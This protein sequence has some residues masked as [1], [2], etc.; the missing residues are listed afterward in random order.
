MAAPAWT[1]FSILAVG[2]AILV[3]LLARQTAALLEDPEG[4]VADLPRRGLY[5]NVVLSHGLVLL[6]VGGAVLVTGVPIGPF[7]LDVAPTPVAAAA[8]GVSVIAV[9]EI[10]DRIA[11]AL[12]RGDNPLRDRLTP[13][14]PGQWIL[15]AGVILPL[16]AA[17]EELLFRGALIGVLDA[18]TGLHPALLIA[19]SAIAFGGAHSAQGSLGVAMA[20]GI[21]LV[22]GIAYALTGSLWL[23]IVVHY[24]VD[25]IEFARHAD[26]APVRI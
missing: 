3:V 1:V 4:P 23:V 25:L 14:T 2:L 17:T 10:A 22:F 13:D 16:V 12:D 26:V 8:L 11:S 21:G 24:V 6:A 5:L 15:L 18:G 19:A 7:G 20:T 9:N